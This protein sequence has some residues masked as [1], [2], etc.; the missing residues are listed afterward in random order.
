MSKSDGLVKGILDLLVLE[1][2]SLES[3]H[4]WANRQAGST[5]FE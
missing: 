5:D 1:T 4:N 3:E 2:V